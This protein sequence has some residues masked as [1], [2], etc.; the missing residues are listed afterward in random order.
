MKLLIIDELSFISGEAL[1]CLSRRLQQMFPG[2]QR[3]FG[4]IT[5]VLLGDL[6]QLPPVKAQAPY[7]SGARNLAA[8]L[9]WRQFSDV[10]VL[11]KAF[12]QQGAEQAPFRDLLQRLSH[13]QSTELDWQMLMQRRKH[14]LSA[15]DNI[16]FDKEIHLFA[17]NRDADEL[18]LKRLEA[19]N[20]PVL[21]SVA[22]ATGV[23][24][25]QEDEEG[26]SS[27]PVLLLCVGARV[28]LRKN[29]W[30]ETGLS[31]F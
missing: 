11:E 4:G 31:L 12:R 2:D 16:E 9:L 29:L 5:I 23:A 27:L 14:V 6:M 3:P 1:V 28:M 10:F 21:R 8:R 17:S 25:E 26:V 22:V 20:Q 13:G 19:L 7:E 30:V 15:E 18:N 24:A